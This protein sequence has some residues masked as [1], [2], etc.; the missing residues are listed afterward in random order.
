MLLGTRPP[1]CSAP[2]CREGAPSLLPSAIPG[3]AEPSTPALA[4]N[5]A[6]SAMSAGKLLSKTCLNCCNNAATCSAA[7]HLPELGTTKDLLFSLHPCFQPHS[8]GK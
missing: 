7:L 3:A 2:P 1:H 5:S 4:T 8:S 6:L